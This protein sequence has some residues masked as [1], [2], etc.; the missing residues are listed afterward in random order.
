MGDY[1]QLRA[2]VLAQE[3]AADVH[4]A[5]GE[6]SGGFHELRDQ[7]RRA[8]LSVPTNIAE[9]CDRGTDRE[10]AR[11]L[12]IALSSASEVESLLCSA[13]KTGALPAQAVRDLAARV[14]LLRRMLRRLIDAIAR[15]SADALRR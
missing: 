1:T 3:V 5:T 13:G 14:G 7:L 15:T 6:A 4:A 8:S 9:G 2:W 10:F 12:R 11:F